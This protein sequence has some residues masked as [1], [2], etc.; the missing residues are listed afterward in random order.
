MSMPKLQQKAIER[1]SDFKGDSTTFAHG[2][3]WK[4][5]LACG[6]RNV[7]NLKKIPIRHLAIENFVPSL[8]VIL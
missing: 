5:S 7:I 2:S 6:D 4:K 8:A 3:S 1:R